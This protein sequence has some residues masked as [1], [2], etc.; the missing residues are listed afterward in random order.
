LLNDLYT[1]Y[2]MQPARQA[3][4]ETALSCKRS[5]SFTTQKSTLRPGKSNPLCTFL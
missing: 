3:L 4:V 1:I 2:T 5:I